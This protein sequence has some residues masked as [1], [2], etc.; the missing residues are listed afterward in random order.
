MKSMCLEI[1]RGTL[2]CALK[3]VLVVNENVAFVSISILRNL[4]L[5]NG[6]MLWR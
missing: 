4:Y 3:R 2:R 5:E 6:E 1:S